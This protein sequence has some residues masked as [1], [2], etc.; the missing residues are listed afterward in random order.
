MLF[1]DLDGF[2][3]VDDAWGHEVGDRLLKAVAG[4]LQGAVRG[5][6]KAARFGGDEFAFLQMPVD[7]SG[8]TA[9]LAGHLVAMLSAPYD[10]GQSRMHVEASI[11]VAFVPFDAEVAGDLLER[12]DATLLLLRHEYH[13]G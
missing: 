12:A 3:A 5:C 11:D 9:W 8:Q 7:E 1:I 13:R 10:I 4:R 2:K 6:D